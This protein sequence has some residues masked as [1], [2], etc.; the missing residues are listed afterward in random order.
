VVVVA[1]V[2]PSMG[3]QAADIEKL[4]RRLDLTGGAGEVIGSPV[5]CM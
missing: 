5:R 2:G 4:P 1:V 3:M